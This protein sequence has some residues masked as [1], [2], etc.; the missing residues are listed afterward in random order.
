MSRKAAPEP[1]GV[2]QCWGK[3]KAGPLIWRTPAH[4]LACSIL[5]F[6]ETFSFLRN[7]LGGTCATKQASST[8]RNTP[9]VLR[10]RLIRWEI[11][12]T[13]VG[14]P[15]SLKVVDAIYFR[16]LPLVVLHCPIYFL[17]C[18]KRHILETITGTCNWVSVSFIHICIDCFCNCNVSS[19]SFWHNAIHLYFNVLP[20]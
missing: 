13:C 16:M 2:S 18:F 19:I 7:S 10:R 4:L 15:R 3:C 11:E 1:L 5:R 20:S 9:S 17:V 6:P 14:G 8:L 12:N